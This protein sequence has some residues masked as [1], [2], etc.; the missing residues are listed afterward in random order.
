MIHLGTVALL[1]GGLSFMH[2]D[3]DGMVE[4]F[5]VAVVCPVLLLPR[6]VPLHPVD[7][8]DRYT[9]LKGTLSL[10]LGRRTYRTLYIVTSHEMSGHFRSMLPACLA[11][12][13]SPITL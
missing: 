1:R 5:P 4:L 9:E 13:I 8:L 7:L 3:V 2:G 6:P 10:W 12:H 11:V